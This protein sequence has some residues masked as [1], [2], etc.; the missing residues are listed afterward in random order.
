MNYSLMPFPSA[1]DS[2][3]P[4]IR[5][6]LRERSRVVS[7]HCIDNAELL[8]E[9]VE[10]LR[11]LPWQYQVDHCHEQD[12]D[13]HVAVW[14][15]D[16][17]RHLDLGDRVNAGIFL[18]N[19]ER[20]AFN[21]FASER[22]FRVACANGALLECEQ[23][24]SLEIAR[25][26]NP[27]RWRDKL[28]DVV[29]RSFSADGL[30]TDLARFRVTTEQML[31]TPYELLCNLEA[32]GLISAD[33]QSDIQEAFDEAADFSLYGLINSVTQSAHRLRLSDAWTRA[34]QIERLGGE[35]LRGDHNLPAWDL[36]RK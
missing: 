19:S 18:Q 17:G 25:A 23:G 4:D 11:L 24:Q 8:D 32:Q 3:G 20:A 9:L 7:K 22:V 29:A 31:L 28:H 14:A 35:I 2:G 5:S 36:V 34:F 6:A 30:E 13:L 12:G 33:E 1:R 26:D 10:A 27:D 21:T 16:L 15:G